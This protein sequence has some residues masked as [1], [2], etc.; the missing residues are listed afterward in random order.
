[1][2]F[3]DIKN[4][5]LAN[6]IDLPPA[7]SAAVPGLINTAIRSAERRYNFKYMEKKQL[8]ITS[9]YV[10]ALSPSIARFKEY[11]DRGP[12]L[13]QQYAPARRI[14]TA[15]DSGDIDQVVTMNTTLPGDM[16]RWMTNTV[17]DS[18]NFI[19]SVW[20]FPDNLSDWSD[21]NYRVNIPYNVYS[22][23]FAADADTNWLINFA[24]DYIAFRATAEAF[25]KDWDYN[26][27]AL[28]KQQDQDKFNEVKQA[29]KKLRLSGIDT[30]TPHWEGAEQGM[31]D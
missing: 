6:V 5:V 30:W 14:F 17:D 7:V 18:G 10:Q 9:P 24:D 31:V 28:W 27:L 2:T 21:G 4:Q 19:F 26:S 25:M 23:T 16:P 3:L 1:M 15:N 29:D 8:F 11:R 13:T 12:Y 20:P 22:P